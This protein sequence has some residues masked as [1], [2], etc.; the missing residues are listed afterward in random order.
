M[1]LN[2]AAADRLVVIPPTRRISIA[3]GEFA[4]SA[5]PGTMITTVLGS[6]VAACIR[7]PKTGLGGMNHYVLPRPVQEGPMA[8]DMARYG[9]RL[10]ELLVN[11]LLSQGAELSRL[12]AKIFGGANSLSATSSAGRSNAEFAIRFLKVAG[13]RLQMAS[14]G[15]SYGCKLEY[16][17]FSGK[18]VRRDLTGYLS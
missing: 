14:I 2:T 12:E 3:Q 6:C 18:T 10:M 8:G 7:D 5:D 16:W 1:A 13:I 17:P 4:V 15:G 9:F 11:E